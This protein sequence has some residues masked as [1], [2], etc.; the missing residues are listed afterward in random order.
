MKL[1]VNNM[2]NNGDINIVKSD[3]LLTSKYE[4]ASSVERV[5]SGIK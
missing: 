3:V 4:F 5:R 2:K 1:N